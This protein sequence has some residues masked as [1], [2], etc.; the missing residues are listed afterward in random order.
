MLNKQQATS[1]TQVVLSTR[2]FMALYLIIGVLLINF[3]DY[4]IAHL[5]TDEMVLNNISSIK[6]W[7]HLFITG[8]ITALLLQHYTRIIQHSEINFQQ[9]IF[10]LNNQ[11]R[12]LLA[13][14]EELQQQVKKLY[15]IS[16]HD[17]LTGLYNRAYFEQK[18]QEVE[19]TEQFPIT[20]FIC[21]LDGLKLI[22]D[23]LGHQVGDLLLKAAADTLSKAFIK[24]TIIARIGGDEFAILLPN[25]PHL[26]ALATYQRIRV[27]E[28]EYNEQ[29][30]PI[31]LT[32]SMGFAVSSLHSTNMNE[33][34]LEADNNMYKEK[35][36]RKSQR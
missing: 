27:A 5:L 11:N 24:D 8:T 33:L 22:N 3:F 25:T 6:V 12:E 15:Y 7:I 28:L 4:L 9:N 14:Q 35:S 18:I 26:E 29:K 30:H 36:R 31:T 20:L 34:F 13:T 2:K 21:D 19:S 10:C 23:S 16:L 1:A 17:H 32:I